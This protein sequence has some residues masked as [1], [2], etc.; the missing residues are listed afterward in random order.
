MLVEKP[1]GSYEVLLDEPTY[2]V[3]RIILNPDQQI[4]LQY[5]NHRF[6]YWTIVE[7]IWYHN[8]ERSIKGKS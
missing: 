4:S 8:I 6:E 3:K 7:V 1:W 5:H 2:K